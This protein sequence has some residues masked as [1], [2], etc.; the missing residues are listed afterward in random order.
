MSVLFNILIATFLISLC[1]W[2][3]VIFL[4]LKKSFLKKIT[5]FLVS[6][7]AGTLMGGAFL[8]LLPEASEVIKGDL[9]YLL[10]LASFLLFFLMEKVLYWRHCHDEDCKIHTFG[11]MNLFGN[12]VHNFIDG[13]I[14]ASTFLI[15]Y[16]LGVITTLAIVSHEIPQELGN[17]GVLTHSGFGRKK[18]LVVNYL[19]SLTVIL[20][21][22][23]G[24]L[25]NR[26]IHDILPYLL[27]FAAGG[28]IYIA[29]TDL[30]P[31][32]KDHRNLKGSII[33]FLVFIFGVLIMYG[34]KFIG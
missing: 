27:P 23:V 9:L 24:Y 2:V 34:I 4:Y 25:I 16:K 17:F 19:I 22:V 3:S 11:Y 31:E 33:S 15:D 28:F 5:I 18:A 14:I 26:S 10:V 20:G 21:G 13:L 7:S 6:L 32:M 8:H 30:I 12:G 29:A 1:V